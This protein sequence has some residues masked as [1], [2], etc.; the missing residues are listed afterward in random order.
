MEGTL[1]ATVSG[2]T[3]QNWSRGTFQYNSR[4]RSMAVALL[5]P[6]ASARTALANFADLSANPVSLIHQLAPHPKTIFTGADDSTTNRGPV[7]E[8]CQTS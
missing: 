7:F 8:R 4:R 6:N 1:A 2:G 5:R 3:E